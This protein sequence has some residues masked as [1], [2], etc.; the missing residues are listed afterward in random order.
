MNKKNV[1]FAFV[2]GMLCLGFLSDAVAA[3]SV[4]RLGGTNAYVGTSGAVSAKSGASAKAVV[5][6]AR[7]PSNR[8][9]RLTSV[10]TVPAVKTVSS[11]AVSDTSRLSVGKYLHNAGQNAGIIKPISGSA[12]SPAEVESL[13]GRVTDLESKIETLDNYYTKEEIEARNYVTQEELVESNYA[14]KTELDTVSGTVSEIN[15][16]VSALQERVAAVENATGAGA[17][18]ADNWETQKPVF[19]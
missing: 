18:V 1:H 4:K 10:K 12:V 3:P 6:G 16:T 15:T 5:T 8:S 9:S 17:N 11:S 13:T 14:T 19:E 7:A 2:I